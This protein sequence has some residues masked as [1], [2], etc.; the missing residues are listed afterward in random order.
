MAA[1]QKLAGTVTTTPKKFLNTA[2]QSHW[3]D[4]LSIDTL[5]AAAHKSILHPFVAWMIPLG[6]R[7]LTTPYSHPT[8]RASVLWATIVSVFVLLGMLDQRIAGG[9]PRVVRLD[10]E[11]VVVTGGASGLGALLVEIYALRGASIAVLD[12]AVEE[13]RGDT[14]FYKC[15]VGDA[16]QVKECCGRIVQDFGT[17]PTILINNAGVVNGKNILDLSEQDITR[18]IQTNLLS[19]FWLTKALLPGMLTAQKGTIVTISSVLGKLGAARLSDYTASKAGLLA[20]HASLTTEIHA[21]PSSRGM[22]KTLLVTPGQLSTPLF[23]GVKTPSR[24]LAPVVDAKDVATRIVELVG[25]GVDGEVSLPE[26]ARWV[27]VL[28]ALPRG[29]RGWVRG[30]SGVDSAMGGWSP[31]GKEALER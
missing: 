28:E 27:W 25:R 29:L 7:A 3:Q 16:Q 6:L 11:L 23:R 13:G 4:H 26:Y 8:M 30:W 5:L 12:L 21:E 1:P 15:D 20:L 17:A 2:P 10:E 14:R 31:G 19:H 9:K 24:F 22:I 18:C